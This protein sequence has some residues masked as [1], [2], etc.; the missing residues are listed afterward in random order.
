MKKLLS[1]SVAL[2]I[3]LGVPLSVFADTIDQSNHTGIT[4]IGF[5]DTGNGRDYMCQ[6]FYPATYNQVTAIGFYVNSKDGNSNIGYAMW[7]DNADTNS[8]PTGAVATGIGGFTEISNATLNTSGLT[9]YTLTSPVNVTIGNKYT[10]CF[11][12]WNTST[13]VWA[14]S[15]HDWVSSTAN[16]YAPAGFT[17]A[18][19]VHLN[20]SFANPTAPD[21]GNDDIIFD[22]Y[23]QTAPTASP[24]VQSQLQI[25]GG[26]QLAIN[27]GAQLIIQ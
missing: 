9:K 11:A 17:G 25:N 18:K 26:T 15:Y 2:L 20:G 3:T 21:L 19:R 1:L 7:I 24:N 23:G 8:N 12:P 5:G 27:G 22:E 6:G 16:P 10:A 13:H 4:G 14:S